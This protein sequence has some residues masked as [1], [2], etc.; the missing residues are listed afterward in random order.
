G[1]K[2]G[3]RPIIKT[4]KKGSI[5]YRSHCVSTQDVIVSICGLDTKGMKKKDV[6]RLLKETESLIELKL[7]YEIQDT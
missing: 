5:A 3:L 1:T 4:V 7:E 6:K 2:Y